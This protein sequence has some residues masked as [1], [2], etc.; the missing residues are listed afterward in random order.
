MCMCVCIIKYIFRKTKIYLEKQKLK[1]IVFN[2]DR[3]RYIII[4]RENLILKLIK[5]KIKQMH[6]LILKG[7]KEDEKKA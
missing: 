4:F 7:H 3:E 6:T 5:R 1:N 2:I